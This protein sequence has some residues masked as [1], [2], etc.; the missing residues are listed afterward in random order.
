MSHDELPRFVE[1]AQEGVL[2]P[3]DDALCVGGDSL[4]VCYVLEGK[5]D[6]SICSRSDKAFCISCGP[7]CLLGLVDVFSEGAPVLFRAV[8][9]TH[10]R[11]FFWN[12]EQFERAIGMYQELARDAIQTLSRRLRRVNKF[13]RD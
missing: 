3:G 11:V 1:R 9:S 5:L 6:L 13:S 7:G 2:E 8:A 4:V 10:A 12:R